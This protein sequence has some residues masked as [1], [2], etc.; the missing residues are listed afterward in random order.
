M[1][2]PAL[3]SRLASDFIAVARTVARPH[4]RGALARQSV[5]RSRNLARHDRGAT[6]AWAS[7]MMRDVGF[8]V[9]LCAVAVACGSRVAVNN[10]PV[11]RADGA[12]P[13]AGA[14]QDQEPGSANVTSGS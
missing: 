3:I 5:A 13:V 14:Q 9:A 6:R 2:S 10:N 12:D 11:S 1:R 4:Q 8:M 7:P